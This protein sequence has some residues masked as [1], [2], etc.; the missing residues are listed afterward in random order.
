MRTRGCADENN[1]RRH[2]RRRQIGCGVGDE[3]GVLDGYAHFV[4]CFH[5]PRADPVVGYSYGTAAWSSKA[6]ARER[7]VAV[8]TTMRAPLAC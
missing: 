5:L 6:A 2:L 8:A 1:S 7:S 3:L 4:E